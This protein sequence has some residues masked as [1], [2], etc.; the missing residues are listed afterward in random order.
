MSDSQIWLPTAGG[1][2][3]R[4]NLGHGVFE[5]SAGVGGKKRMAKLTQPDWMS[6][7]MMLKY[8]ST[9]TPVNIR[10]EIQE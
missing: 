10:K 7:A 6:E 8:Q 3:E 5:A 4:A 9:L 1:G 2:G